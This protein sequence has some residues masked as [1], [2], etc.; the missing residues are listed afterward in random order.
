MELRGDE[1]QNT[2][3]RFGVW[4]RE[5]LPLLEEAKWKCTLACISRFA[6]GHIIAFLPDG[7]IIVFPFYLRQAHH[8]QRHEVDQTTPFINNGID[9]N[10]F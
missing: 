10:G 8:P 6:V 7:L 1:T 5:L 2:Y 9:G 4:Q 3:E